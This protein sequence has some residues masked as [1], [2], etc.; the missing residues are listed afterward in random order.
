[1]SIQS[2]ADLQKCPTPFLKD[3]A[4]RIDALEAK[5]KEA[6]ALYQALYKYRDEA[7]R[8]IRERAWNEKLARI[9]KRGT[10]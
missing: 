8:I 5:R 3:L 4:A 1:M 9:L 10:P 6:E 7:S 2:L